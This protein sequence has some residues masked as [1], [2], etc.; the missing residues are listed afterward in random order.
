MKQADFH[1]LRREEKRKAYERKRARLQALRAKALEIKQKKSVEAHASSNS[2]NSL[3][4]SAA[5]LPDVFVGR[6][7][8]VRRGGIVYTDSKLLKDNIIIPADYIHDAQEGDKVVVKLFHRGS[9]R[10]MPEGAVLDVLGPDGENN[11]EMNGILAEYGLPYTYPNVE[12]KASEHIDEA[13]ILRRR[14]MRDKFTFTI[15]PADAKDFDDALSFEKLS[16]GNYEIGVHIADVTH[17]VLPDTDVDAEAYNRG[18]SVYLVDRTV[19]MLPEILSNNIC[20]LRPDE[21]KLTFSVVFTMNDKA[22][23]LS[24]KICP[25]VIRSNARLSYDEAQEILDDPDN[26]PSG[27]GVLKTLNS[28]ARILRK[29]RLDKGAVAFERDEVKFD[30]DQDGHP[31]AIHLKP[32]KEANYLIEEF[33][34]LAN[35]TVATHVGKELRKPFVYRVHDT[36]D[37]EKMERIENLARSLN[38]PQADSLKKMLSKAQDRPEKELLEQLAIRAMA[39]AVYSPEN[40]GH[41]GLAF[42]YYTHFTSPIRRYPDIMVHRL[43]KEYLHIS[44]FTNSCNPDYLDLAC[45]HCSSREQLAASAERASVRYKQVEFM[46]NYVGKHFS[47]IISGVTEWGLYVELVENQCEGLI[48]IR[49]LR[50]ED[51]YSLEEDNFCLRGR[52][53]DRIFRLGDRLTV[54]LEAADLSRKQLDF[55]LV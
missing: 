40:I 9:K 18:T 34:L 36:P 45:R 5:S 12:V 37:P 48:P 13:E 46:Q 43:L 29:A 49:N 21:D 8:F 23:V 55:K 54:Q 11:A 2:S 53:F 30:L 15:D 44:Q 25:T 27:L 38:F 10:H 6:F 28:L 7:E 42:Q 47:A 17:Y 19:P 31:L 22:Q 52:S 41:Y 16:D 32:A 3:N 20:S 39:K 50:P 1:A 33:M 26:N 24:Y 51:Y 35:R 14:D 4:S